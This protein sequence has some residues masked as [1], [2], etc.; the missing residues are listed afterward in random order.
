MIK[1]L[2]EANLLPSDFDPVTDDP[3]DIAPYLSSGFKGGMMAVV[4]YHWE[5]LPTATREA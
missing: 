3:F 5:N 1:R 2:E 4:A